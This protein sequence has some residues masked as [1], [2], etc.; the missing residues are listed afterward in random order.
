VV[1]RCCVSDL[2]SNT[3]LGAHQ[4]LSDASS[5][6]IPWSSCIVLDWN[7]IG[8]AKTKFWRGLELRGGV[9]RGKPA[10]VLVLQHSQTCSSLLGLSKDL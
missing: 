10:S 4:A 1:D 7:L 5:S 3:I 8:N 2:Q 9:M 6:R